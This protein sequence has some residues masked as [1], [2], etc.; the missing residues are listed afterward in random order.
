MFVRLLF[1]ERKGGL[2][3]RGKQ[4]GD[5]ECTPYKRWARGKPVF[6]HLEAVFLIFK[7][8][9]SIFPCEFLVINKGVNLK[10]HGETAFPHIGRTNGHGFSIDNYGFG[11]EKAIVQ[12][13]FDAG[14]FRHARVT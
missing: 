6:R 2:H 10:I 3:E 5:A 12:I 7:E 13:D 14:V 1:M 11:M 8:Y 9:F 4:A